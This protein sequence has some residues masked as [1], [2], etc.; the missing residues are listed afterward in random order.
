MQVRIDPNIAR[1]LE[2]HRAGF[3]A[4]AK[5]I[6]EAAIIRD[7]NDANAIGLLG[8]VAIQEGNR[9]QAVSL[10]RKSLSRQ[11]DF[12][13]Y[14][15]NLNNLIVTLL[16]DSRDAEARTLLENAEIPSGANLSLPDERELRSIASLA[17]CLQRLNLNK[18]ARALF[19]PVAALI[20]SDPGAMRL[21]ASVRFDDN[22]FGRALEI[23]KTFRETDDLWTVTTR[24]RC[25]GEL[26]LRAEAAVDYEKLL[27]IAPVYV[28]DNNSPFTILFKTRSG[29]KSGVLAHL[30]RPIV[31]TKLNAPPIT[32]ANCAG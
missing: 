4:D 2:L 14:V 29:F 8:I 24:L 23:L 27:Q 18:K 28:A 25:E 22:D 21:L 13:T 10:W 17:M 15:R 31:D 32:F 20:P 16:E 3:V 7:E 26:G 30:P 11:S 5:A 12:F 19:E 9:A 6:Y 1:A